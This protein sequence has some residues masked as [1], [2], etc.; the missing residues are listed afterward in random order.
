MMIYLDFVVHNKANKYI[1]ISETNLITKVCSFFFCNRAE[2]LRDC[3]LF[4]ILKNRVS[5]FFILRVKAKINWAKNTAYY[6]L[7]VFS[8]LLLSECLVL[9]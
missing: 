6:F 8:W 1:N 7:G 5:Y 3:F 2:N 9:V 4:I